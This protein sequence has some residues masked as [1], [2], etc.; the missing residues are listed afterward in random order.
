MSQRTPL[1]KTGSIKELVTQ[2]MFIGVSE[3]ASTTIASAFF[4]AYLLEHLSFGQL[5]IVLSTISFAVLLLDY[6]TGRLA[7]KIGAQRVMYLAYSAYLV[8]W[9]LY[10]FIQ[11]SFAFFVMISVIWGFA[12]AQASGTSRAWFINTFKR[13]NGNSLDG[14]EREYSRVLSL[15]QLTTAIIV[16]F[17]GLLAFL[18]CPQAVFLVGI[19]CCGVTIALAYRFMQERE[20][21]CHIVINQDK[22]NTEKPEARQNVVK[23]NNTLQ[24]TKPDLFAEKEDKLFSNMSLIVSLALIYAFTIIVFR[25]QRMTFQPVTL[26]FG[27][28]YFMLSVFGSLIVLLQALGFYL[29]SKMTIKVSHENQLIIQYS[30]FTVICFMFAF[31][32]DTSNVL[33]GICW[34]I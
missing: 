33:M 22:T 21:K 29:R 26:D 28:N 1:R 3:K 15:I 9:L 34:I 13:N 7:D 11:G 18:T 16:F 6:P 24:G 30:A 14:L 12:T 19:G 25:T 27:Y 10:I 2:Y 17:G 32:T 4:I 31:V 5:G 8:G 20:G 23:A